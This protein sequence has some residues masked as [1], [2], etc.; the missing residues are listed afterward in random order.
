MRELDKVAENLFD[1]IRT[2]FENV[3]LGDEKS[4]RTSDPEKARFFNFDYV[5]KDGENFGNVTMSI[6]DGDSLKIYFSKN[7]TDNLD[8]VQQ[9]EWFNFLRII[10]QFAKQNFLSFDARDI[11]KS[12]LDLRDIQQQSKADAKFTGND[13]TDT[14]TVSES[15]MYGTRNMSFQECGP[16]KIRVKHSAAVDEERHGARS[17]NIEAIYL[18]NHLG[19]RRLLPFTNLHGARAMAMHC[20]QGGDI[21]D[22]IGRSIEGM[23]T[24]MGAM[25]HFVREAKRRQ[26]ED[27][28]TAQMADAAVSHYGELKNKLHHLAGH[29]GYTEFRDSYQP[30]GDIEDEFD[31]DELRERFVKK[32]YNEKFTDA[33]PYVYRAYKKQQESLAT[34]MGDQFESWVHNVA[35][36]AFEGDDERMD[37][38]REVMAQPL[39]VGMDGMDA[40]MALQEIFDDE[41]LGEHMTDLANT[42][43]PETD[44]RQTVLD[45]MRQNGM[46]YIADN[47]EEELAQQPVKTKQ[48]MPDEEPEE[49]SAEPAPQPTA[50]Q[51]QQGQPQPGG[52]APVAD[53]NGMAIPTESAD[54]LALIRY[55]AG[56]RKR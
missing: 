12:G 13:V 49:P 6:V 11:N 34:P 38:L 32:V 5:A 8:D 47:I 51:P 55:L 15:K 14:G 3:N 1:K 43:G 41:S 9:D 42:E 53:P 18:D 36:D 27:A 24:E 44:A 35:E 25:R 54:P 21:A 56:M 40:T 50:P 10:R 28:E 19:E 39:M 23:V 4:K 33:L 31:V 16:V 48:D 30:E 20:S 46:S 45:W 7:I 29:R 22:D 26:F 37:A 17:R 52:Q 2:R